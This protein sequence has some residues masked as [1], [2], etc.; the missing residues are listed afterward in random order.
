MHSVQELI[1]IQSTSTKSHLVGSKCNIFSLEH[2]KDAIYN[3]FLEA[4]LH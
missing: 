3:T 4:L 1:F 2:V